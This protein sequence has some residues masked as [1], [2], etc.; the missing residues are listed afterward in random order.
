MAHKKKLSNNLN[1]A[2]NGF[3]FVFHSVSIHNSNLLAVVDGV[4]SQ[5]SVA[6][7]TLIALATN[8]HSNGKE[9]KRNIRFE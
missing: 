4:R 6:K 5:K 9:I 2:C 7:I 8:N 1:K 3:I